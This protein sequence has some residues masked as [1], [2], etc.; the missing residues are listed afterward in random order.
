MQVF[1]KCNLI[2]VEIQL[3]QIQFLTPLHLTLWDK[4]SRSAILKLKNNNVW[5]TEAGE[6][7]V[8]PAGQLSHLTRPCLKIINRKSAGDVAQ[9]KVSRFN[10]QFCQKLK[11]KIR[12][13]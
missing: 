5:E 1:S 3:G 11:I 2:L 9:C 6:V 10:L 7:Q 4:Q 12:K 8:A 13:Q